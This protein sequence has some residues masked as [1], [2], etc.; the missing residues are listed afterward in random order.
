MANEAG[1]ELSLEDNKN[2]ERKD[3]R[4]FPVPGK[5]TR[6]GRVKVRGSAE[7]ARRKVRVTRREEGI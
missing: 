3:G 7:M 1:W 6:C 5:G 4:A 2:F